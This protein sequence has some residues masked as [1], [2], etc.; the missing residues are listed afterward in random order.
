MQEKVKFND[1]L[2]KV[3]DV[4]TVALMA[5]LFV[6][7]TFQ[8]FNRLIL[9]L[10]AAW[11]EEMGRYCFVWLSMFGSV[12]ALHSRVHLNVDIVESKLTGNTRLIV[13][14]LAEIIVLA[15]CLILTVTGFKYTVSNIGNYCEFGKFPI[16]VIYMVMPIAGSLMCLVSIQ[17]LIAKIRELAGYNSAVNA[18]SNA[19]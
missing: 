1:W 17:M 8:V 10:P 19:E 11:T 5:C 3:I 9:H 12:K 16:F 14:I 2:I 4:I 6:M 15:F 18:K 13:N 7:I